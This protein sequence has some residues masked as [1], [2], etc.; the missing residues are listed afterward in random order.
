MLITRRIRNKK[1]PKTLR[2]AFSSRYRSLVERSELLGKTLPNKDELWLKLWAEYNN[3]FHCYYCGKHLVVSEPNPAT[4]VFSFDHALPFAQGGDNNIANIVICCH[5][6]N[7]IKGTMKS[8]TF[9]AL[10]M[11]LQP[12]PQLKASMFEEVRRGRLADKLDRVQ[13]ERIL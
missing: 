10:M 8:T 7:I 4:S 13:A 11:L 6:C 5:E 9:Q 3:G 12:Y 1:M 2:E